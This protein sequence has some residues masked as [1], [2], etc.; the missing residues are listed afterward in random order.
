MADTSAV[1]QSPQHG[2]RLSTANMKFA[3]DLYKLHT[4]SAAVENVFMSPLSISV[5]LAMTYAGA[6]G[7]TS[8]QM[9][10]VLHF[11]DVEQ[12][13]GQSRIVHEA[14]SEIQ[15]A[16]NKPGQPYKLYMAN[17]LFGDKSYSF[18]DEFLAAGRKHYGAD[19]A[20][21]DFR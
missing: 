12:E 13:E 3:L 4:S 14:F 21:V 9:H 10:T 6:R 2:T 20:A 1:L 16:L 17:R 7:R 18:L 19:L 15:S 8:S 5:A 11:S